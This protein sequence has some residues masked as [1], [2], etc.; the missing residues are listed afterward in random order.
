M[1]TNTAQEFTIIVTAVAHATS[2][3]EALEIS[4]HRLRQGHAFAEVFDRTDQLV[5]EATLYQ[6]PCP[7]AP[8]PQSRGNLSIISRN[9]SR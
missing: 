2:P 7:P 6:V 1:D 8:P 4:K 9:A 5:Q 3:A